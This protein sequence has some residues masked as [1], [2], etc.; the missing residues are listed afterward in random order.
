MAGILSKIT[1]FGTFFFNSEF[2][3]AESKILY[4]PLESCKLN[5]TKDAHSKMDNLEYTEIKLQDYMKSPNLRMEEALNIFKFR[6]RMAEF[7]EN[8]RAG[9]D[10]V[11][12][13]LCSKDEKTIKELDNQAHSF[14]CNVIR[15]EIE[16]KGE[17]IKVYN[18]D[19]S[20]E[21]AETITK[22]INIRKKLLK[23]EDN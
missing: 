7:G 6:M 18:G 13:P 14:Q 15:K 8:F 19:I 12:C 5:D 1:R 3:F 20:K 21:V 16:V 22:I 2:R 9:A 17:L 23:I 11:F 4:E 10:Y